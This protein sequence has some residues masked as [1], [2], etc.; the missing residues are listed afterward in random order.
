MQVSK[1]SFKAKLISSILMVFAL[2]ISIFAYILMSFGAIRTELR[3]VIFADS[4][5]D[6]FFEVVIGHLRWAEDFEIY[7]STPNAKL[8]IELDPTKC[9]FGEW[10]HSKQRESLDLR[11]PNLSGDIMHLSQI[12]TALHIAAYEIDSLVQ[13]GNSKNSELIRGLQRQKIYAPINQIRIITNSV[14][15]DMNHNIVTDSTL[16]KHADIYMNR[17][18]IFLIIVAILVILGSFYL[19]NFF[20]KKV[21]EVIVHTKSIAAGDLRVEINEESTDE[22]GEINKS[23]NQLLQKIS[24]VVGNVKQLA[25]HV[26]VASGEI[27]KGSQLISQGA[28]MQASASE[29]IASSMEI[30]SASVERTSQLAK[31]TSNLTSDTLNSLTESANELNGTARDFELIIQKVQIISDIAYQTNILA[32]NAS[33]EAARAGNMGKGFAVVAENVRRLAE[34]TRG[35]VKDIARMDQVGELISKISHNISTLLDSNVSQSVV[36]INEVANVSL[37]QSIGINELSRAM[38]ELNNVTQRNAA[39]SEELAT[40]AEELSSQTHSLLSEIQYFQIHESYS[41]VFGKSD[42]FGVESITNSTKK[43]DTNQ[44]RIV[45]AKL[46]LDANSRDDDFERF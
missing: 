24:A 39:S 44:Q 16:E 46:N 10:L 7:L 5:Q 32:L 19:A 34:E 14:I 43:E 15:Q 35:I 23:L 12:H 26:S 6:N 45:G 20:S 27:S 37:E 41:Q 38:Q 28:S 31:Q 36:H 21:D 42:T 40:S 33:I 18:K 8:D 17:G 13:K 30:I 3:D 22:F 25:M 2:T 1:V 4:I 9:T 11:S 29:E